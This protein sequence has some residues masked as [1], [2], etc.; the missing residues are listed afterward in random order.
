M[1]RTMATINPEAK[2]GLLVF[3][4]VVILIAMAMWLGGMRL[5]KEDAIELIV[6]FP[7]AAGLDKGASVAVAGVEV[8]RVKEIKLDRRLAQLTLSINKK[9]RV[10]NDFAAIMKSRGLLGEKYVE[11]IPGSPDA[12]ILKHGD[13]ITKTVSYTDMDKLVDVLADVAKDIQVITASLKASIGGDKGTAQIQDIIKNLNEITGSVNKV[14]SGNSD[15]LDNIIANLDTIITNVEAES[16]GILKGMR[17]VSD[18]LNEVIAENRSNLSEG[19]ENLKVASIKLQE[20]MDSINKMTGKIGPEV[21]ETMTSIGNVAKKID[22]GEGTLGKLVNDPETVERLNRTL[23]G[24]N[25]FIDKGESFKTYIGYR[26]EFLFDASETKSYLTLKLAPRKDKYYI[27]EIID[28]PRG[29]R[30]VETIKTTTGGLSSET[31]YVRTSD[32]LLFSAQV[33]KEVGD[34]T[35]RGGLIESTG[36]FGIDYYAYN[37]TLKVSFDAFDFDRERNP[38]L[39]AGATYYFGKYFYAVAG[40]DDFISRIGLESPY[41]GLGFH[42][43]DEDLKYILGSIPSMQF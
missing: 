27:I 26:A 8:G 20:T 14:L 39:K 33:A 37:D 23:T 18:N 13:T 19:I 36:G 32:D 25:K 21:T 42:F 10:G 9:V 2:V 31:E 3:I 6:Y 7:S 17:D 11:L 43:E 35:L 15:K 29:S 1:Y 22:S 4:G 12:E 30:E 34:F 5:G 28:A 38:H 16:P 24:I 41:V 40:Y